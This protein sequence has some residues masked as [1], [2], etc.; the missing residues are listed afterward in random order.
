MVLHFMNPLEL[1]DIPTWQET[2][3]S[4][5]RGEVGKSMMELCIDRRAKDFLLEVAINTE[6]A[7]S[8]VSP[9]HGL[10]YR[11]RR[12]NPDNQLDVLI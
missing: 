7:L 3:D 1:K 11:R 8:K 6:K 4:I 9:K 5:R 12:L 10:A 2:W